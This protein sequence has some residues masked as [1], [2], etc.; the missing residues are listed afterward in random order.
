MLSIAVEQVILKVSG[1][2]LQCIYYYL[3]WFCGLMRFILALLTYDL[4]VV[5]GRQQLGLESSEG[6]TG[7]DVQGGPHLC[8]Q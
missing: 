2:K 8:W 6:S 4:H 1:L 3:S 7:V 5:I